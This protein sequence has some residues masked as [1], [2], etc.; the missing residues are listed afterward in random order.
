MKLAHSDAELFALYYDKD[1]YVNDYERRLYKRGVSLCINNP[2]GGILLAGINP[3]GTD[4]ERKSTFYDF[5]YAGGMFWDQKRKLFTP[6]LLEKTAYLDLFPQKESTQEVFEKKTSVDFRARM[7]EITQMEIER[8]RP[9][10]VIIA[11]KQSQH[12]WGFRKDTTWMGYNLE[13]V[14]EDI[15]KGKEIFL[16][17]INGFRSEHDRVNQDRLKTTN[18]RYI[19][20]YAMYDQRHEVK[21]ADR[22]LT[23]E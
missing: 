21:C 1:R 17:K 10:L 20:L 13:R 22:V 3:S 16:Y 14:N 8:L 15:V 18:L 19:L 2:V 4:A 11:N 6:A 9:K 23:A 12:Y 5:K 7:I